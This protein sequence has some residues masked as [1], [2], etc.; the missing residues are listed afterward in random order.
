VPPRDRIDLPSLRLVL[1]VLRVGRDERLGHFDALDQK[2][3]LTIGFAGVLVT[4]S[5]N[6]TEPW[7]ALGVLASVLATELALSSFWPR[8]LL[9]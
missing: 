3:G 7:R 8:R 6:I 1:D 9:D 4:L 2:A 5:N